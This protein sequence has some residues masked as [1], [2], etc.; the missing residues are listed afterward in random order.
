MP[1]DLSFSSGNVLLIS[2]I[3][4]LILA[5]L[6]TL[7]VTKLKNRMAAGVIEFLMMSI[8]VYCI[9]QGIAYKDIFEGGKLFL[10]LV[11]GSVIV[12]G[13]LTFFVE[14][15]KVRWLA[16][17]T[18]FILFFIAFTIIT[19]VMILFIAQKIDG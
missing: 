8:G 15:T 4:G 19:L 14:R 17:L 5:I 10:P 18:R 6:L 9:A 11:I 7:L 13:L 1:F 3:V 2:P 16:M 12:G